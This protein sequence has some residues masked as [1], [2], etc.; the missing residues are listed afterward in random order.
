MA[1]PHNSGSALRI[2][3]KF[4]RMEVANRYMKILLV[5]F[6]EKKFIWGNLVFLGHFLLFYWACLNSAKPLLL[7]DP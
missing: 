4:Y 7:L 6:Q 5:V 1:H 2:L 3:L